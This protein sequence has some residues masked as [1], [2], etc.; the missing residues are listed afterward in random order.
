MKAA[1]AAGGLPYGKRFTIFDRADK[2]PDGPD[3]DGIAV[4]QKYGTA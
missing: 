2:N 4:D 3:G 1:R